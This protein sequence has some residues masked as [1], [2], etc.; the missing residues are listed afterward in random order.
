MWV[1]PI[2]WV[3]A[4]KRKR[5]RSL[6]E[7]IF[8]PLDCLWTQASV[9]ILL[10]ASGQLTCSAYFGLIKIIFWTPKLYVPILSFSVLLYV[11][12]LLILFSWR[13]LIQHGLCI[14]GTGSPAGGTN[15][16]CT[17]KH[18]CAYWLSL[19]YS[20]R[21]LSGMNAHLSSKITPQRP[22]PEWKYLF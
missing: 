6:K 2:Q 8:L 21:N 10:H 7:Q 14:Q 20:I 16:M 15:R 5:L 18:I 19:S 17:Y 3:E 12:T 22:D 13:T 4:L 9:S 11:H 1:G